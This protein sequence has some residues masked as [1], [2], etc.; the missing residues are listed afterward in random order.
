M[1]IHVRSVFAVFGFASSLLASFSS[2]LLQQLSPTGVI[3]NWGLEAGFEL[4]SPEFNEFARWALHDQADLYR[5]LYLELPG[6]F[7]D[8]YSYQAACEQQIEQIGGL[9]EDALVLALITAMRHSDLERFITFLEISADNIDHIQGG[10]YF[11]RFIF[12][13]TSPITPTCFLAA[14][15]QSANCDNGLAS[16]IDGYINQLNPE[17]RQVFEMF[18]HKYHFEKQEMLLAP[19]KQVTKEFIEIVEL[20]ADAEV[21]PDSTIEKVT[22]GHLEI[23]YSLA[24]N[25]YS[26]LNLVPGMSR[27]DIIADFNRVSD[28]SVEMAAL[29]VDRHEKVGLL[30]K[31][32][33]IYG[34]FFA[35]MECSGDDCYLIDECKKL[36]MD[37]SLKAPPGQ[38][39]MTEFKIEDGRFFVGVPKSYSKSCRMTLNIEAPCWYTDIGRPTDETQMLRP[40]KLNL[41]N[42]GNKFRTSVAYSLFAEVRND[43]DA[44]VVCLEGEREEQ[45]KG[46]EEDIESNVEDEDEDQE[47]DESDESTEEF[48]D[49][50]E[51]HC[52][53]TDEMVD[54]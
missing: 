17:H 7:A 48:L 15:L 25:P 24:G 31:T 11:H 5:V 10:E 36:F 2:N 23:V 27:A 1:K 3:V 47:N 43:G 6:E 9:R 33:N 30:L 37:A 22:L 49:E 42:K 54:C 41:E 35:V 12:E 50:E 44:E 13:I 20:D 34:P 14:Y 39:L 4:G 16:V 29:I 21:E 53:T 18:C 52:P 28:P 51:Q 8:P 46:K 32:S 40:I 19:A 26:K 38:I 45:G